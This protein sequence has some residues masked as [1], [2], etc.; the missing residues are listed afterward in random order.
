MLADTGYGIWALQ[1]MGLAFGIFREGR[2]ES[3][4]PLAV[5]TLF[6]I[7]GLVVASVRAPGVPAWHGWRPGHHAW[8]PRSALIALAS[9]L[10][11]LAG[12]RRRAWPVPPCCRW[13][14]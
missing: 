5:G 1:G 13:D 3:L 7:A 14:A 11:M 9:F 8:P 6:V 2:G 4:V 10:P 12:A